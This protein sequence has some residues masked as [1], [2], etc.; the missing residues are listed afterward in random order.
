MTEKPYN[1]LR[2]LW[3]IPAAALMLYLLAWGVVFATP[4]LLLLPI[5]GASIALC[6]GGVMLLRSIW[7]APS[8][9]KEAR[10][11]SRQRLRMLGFRDRDRAWRE[12]YRRAGQEGRS[13]LAQVQAAEE[14][15]L[16][17]FIDYEA[18]RSEAER[19]R[20]HLTIIYITAYRS[21]RRAGKSEKD[22]DRLARI[23]ERSE[24]EA[25]E[26]KRKAGEET[27]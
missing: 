1:P 27:R 11:R 10:E 2:A 16:D 5:A 4:V 18:N 12:G 23:A 25:I 14:A 6:L 26:S 15:V 17:A 9:A 22:A 19:A 8:P 7:P 20:D 3:A 13:G 21:A 24:K